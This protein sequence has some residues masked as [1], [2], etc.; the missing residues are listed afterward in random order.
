MSD[1][2]PENM[3][4]DWEHERIRGGRRACA[5]PASHRRTCRKCGLSQFM[6]GLQLGAT[7]QATN[8]PPNQCQPKEAL[9]C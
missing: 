5:M 4:H 2:S 6:S 7:Y 3:A 8:N 9:P 1:Y